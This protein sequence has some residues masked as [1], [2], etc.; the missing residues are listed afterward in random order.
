MAL[1]FVAVNLW[2]QASVYFKVRPWI[3][4]I[5]HLKGLNKNTGSWTR[6]YP[7]SDLQKGSTQVWGVGSGSKA[8][9]SKK[10]GNE[11]SVLEDGE[12]GCALKTKKNTIFLPITGP[13][14]RDQ[15]SRPGSLVV[16][17]VGD[18]ADVY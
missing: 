12:R 8:E 14:R 13:C 15:K 16:G 4:H 9:P 7:N 2:C 10:V 11:N 17:V 1:E 3:P 5:S 6:P 18:C